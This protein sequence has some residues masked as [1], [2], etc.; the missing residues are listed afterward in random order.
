MNQIKYQLRFFLPIWFINILTCWLPDNKFSIK[1]RG[2]LVSIFLPGCPKN[3]TLGRDVTLLGVDNLIIG[4]DVYIAKGGWFN[5]KGGITIE[6]EVVFAPYCV[7]VSTAHGFKENSVRWG[8]THFKPVSIGK[9]TWVASHCTIASGTTIG[10]G[11]LIGANSMVN[12][13]FEDNSFLGGVPAKFIKIRQNN[14]G[15]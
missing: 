2:F 5:G 9:G 6:D 3:L 1:I 13:F 7:V 11:C 12:G 4:D 15:I 14:P 10:K 8:G